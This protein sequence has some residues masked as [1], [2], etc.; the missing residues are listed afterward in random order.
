MLIH[1]D[2]KL[3]VYVW[4]DYCYQFKIVL[5]DTIEELCMIGNAFKPSC[6]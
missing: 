5:I 4:V 2:I 3:R 1:K 6:D